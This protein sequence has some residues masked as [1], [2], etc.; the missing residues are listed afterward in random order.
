M[1]ISSQ[2][3][4][5]E[6]N[7]AGTT[8]PFA[9]PFKF[10]AAADLLVVK[11]EIATGVATTL[12]LTTD[13][14]VAG[15]G[16]EAGGSVSTVA[17]LP[18]T[19]RISIIR[20]PDQLQLIDYTPNDKFP[21]ETH[22]RGLDLLTMLIQRL[23]EIASRT[24]RYPEG[25]TGVPI[26]PKLSER[27]D[28]YLGFNAA[29]NLSVLTGTAADASTMNFLQAGAGAVN[30]TVQSK[31]RDV[32]S[33]KDFGAVGDAVTDDTAAIQNALN[34][35]PSGS[36]VM[37][38]VGRYRVSATIT[39]PAT[40]SLWGMGDG[41]G[42]TSGYCEIIGD[43]AVTPVVALT[44]GGASYS[45]SL[46]DFTIGRAAGA[47]PAGSIGL[48]TQVTDSTTID[49]VFI[50]RHAI[51]IK[52][53]GQVG[54][55]FNRVQTGTISETHVWIEALQVN[56]IACQFGRNGG[57]DMN[58]NEYVRIKGGGDTY[59]FAQCQ[60]NLSGFTVNN[61]IVF[62]TYASVNDIF[63]FTGCHFESYA[64]WM[65]QTGTANIG[66]FSVIGCTLN[67]ATPVF[68][69][70][71]NGAISDLTIMGCPSIAGVFNVN[72]QP[73]FS[74]VGNSFAAAVTITAGSGTF[75]ANSLAG[76]FTLTGA[77]VGVV[78][79]GNTLVNAQPFTNT[80]TGIFSVIGNVINDAAIMNAHINTVRGVLN[81]PQ[82]QIAFPA[83]Q[84]SSADPNTFDDY[85]RGTVTLALA[86]AATPGTQTYT[87]NTCSYVKVGRACIIRHAA[88]MSAKDAATAGAMRITGLPFTSEVAAS[89]YGPV[90][91]PAFG[92]ITLTA[93]YTQV[94]GYVQP[95]NTYVNLLQSGS[96]VAAADITAAAIAA[97]SDWMMH[98]TYITAA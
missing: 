4:K 5:I 65:T 82:G 76:A 72:S 88:A 94:G 78:V 83:I 6:Y 81:L 14:T 13:Y 54:V 17:V 9:V 28:K 57:A 26:I 53:L 23:F 60:F 21:A 19:H 80:A 11:T 34:N 40:K 31:L 51:G 47:I 74:I 61:A 52:V 49:D 62:D 18:A 38:P 44:G 59:R 64:N 89:T 56:F 90:S 37:L 7:G 32:V 87:Y 67:S 46:K 10:L 20:D 96:A 91:I 97:N 98:G 95:N 69:A 50:V 12:I 55:F 86:G 63:H 85:E 45:G 1:T 15:A 48:T 41:T 73:R 71:L 68:D 8:G 33:V 29:G 39:V 35:S 70:T 42:T 58:A 2:T 24:I 66:R 27:I 84:N 43:L 77:A 92:N 16:D 3:A 79:S 25:D 36:I 30:R 75:H 93:G 22:E